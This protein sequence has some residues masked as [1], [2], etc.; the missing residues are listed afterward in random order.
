MSCLGGSY[1]IAKSKP[2]CRL[3]SVVDYNVDSSKVLDCAFDDFVS[4]FHGIIIGDCLSPSLH[5]LVDHFV[6]GCARIALPVL[7]STQVIDDH[8][9]AQ[10]GKEEGVSFS[11]S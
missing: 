6:S 10:G 2:V 4:V 9:S 1:G 8:G 5:D 11:E 7:A 3:P